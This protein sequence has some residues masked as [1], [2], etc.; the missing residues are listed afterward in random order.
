MRRL[1]KRL[2]NFRI[3]W[4]NNARILELVI[5]VLYPQDLVKSHLMFAVREEVEV[6]KE[7][8]T[9][10]EEMKRKLE[11]ENTFLRAAVSAETLAKLALAQQQTTPAPNT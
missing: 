3:N 6:L 5:F 1:N 2:K 11:F 8:I 9:E 4:N 7:K 10:L